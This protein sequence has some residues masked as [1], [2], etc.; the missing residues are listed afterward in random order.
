M[1]GGRLFKFILFTLSLVHSCL[2]IADDHSARNP[3]VLSSYE[4]GVDRPQKTAFDFENAIAKLP[5]PIKLFCR[6]LLAS[7]QRMMPVNESWKLHSLYEAMA[8]SSLMTG[9]L[10]RVP[11]VAP[12]VDSLPQYSAYRRVLSDSRQS[13]LLNLKSVRDGDLLISA[14]GRPCG[15]DRLAPI[16]GSYFLK[17]GSF[18]IGSGLLKAS[19]YKRQQC[20]EIKVMRKTSLNP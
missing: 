13:D 11:I 14:V 10:V 1:A 2:A 18:L 17:C 20:S 4:I 9:T 8:D 6:N 7:Q 16:K 5:P 3:E 12:L 15:P 19:D